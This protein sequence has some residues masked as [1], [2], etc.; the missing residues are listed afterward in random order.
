[1]GLLA[2]S[3]IGSCFRLD[4][5]VERLRNARTYGGAAARLAGDG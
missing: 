3:V 4:L 1:M 2:S 5:R